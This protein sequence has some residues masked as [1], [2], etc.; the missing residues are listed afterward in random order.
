MLRLIAHYVAQ[1]HRR[2]FKLVQLQMRDSELEGSGRFRGFKSLRN[3]QRFHRLFKVLQPNVGRT[4]HEVCRGRILIQLENFIRRRDR[5]LRVSCPEMR[6][7]Q[8]Q[9]NIRIRRYQLHRL[10]VSL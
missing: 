4:L 1:V 5:L 6:V 8:I 3:L 9:M 2:L 7:G 10:L